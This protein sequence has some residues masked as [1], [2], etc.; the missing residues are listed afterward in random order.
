MKASEMTTE[1]FDEILPAL[2]FEL[3][4]YPDRYSYEG[5]GPRCLIAEYD[6]PEVDGVTVL[7]ENGVYTVIG[8]DE[9]VEDFNDEI[10]NVNFDAET[11]EREQII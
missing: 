2:K 7:F 11:G 6:R 5:A 4:Q 8:Y 3:L 9:T 10:W 1:K